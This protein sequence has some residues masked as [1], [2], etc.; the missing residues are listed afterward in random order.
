MAEIVETV[1]LNIFN[2]DATNQSISKGVPLSEYVIGKK[3][4]SQAIN[5][6]DILFIGTN[7]REPLF[8]GIRMIIEIYY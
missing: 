7:L 2:I 1:N 8:E 6:S 5:R 3:Y 4:I